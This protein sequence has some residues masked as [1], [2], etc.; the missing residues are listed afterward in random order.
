L[1]LSQAPFSNGLLWMIDV[2]IALGSGKIVAVLALDAHH[3]HLIQAAPS[4]GQVRCLA[5]SVAASWTGETIADLLKRLIAQ[6]G[7]PAA[8]LKDGGGDLH[9]AVALLGE[10]GLASP[11]IDDISHAVARILKRIYQEHPTFATFLPT[12]GRVSGK[13][14]RVWLFFDTVHLMISRCGTRRECCVW[15]GWETVPRRA[16]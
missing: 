14:K 3:H 15:P 11:C 9:K 4:L 5:V 1:P 8:Y 12:C 2:S 16:A 10:Q 6:M 13:L 7:R